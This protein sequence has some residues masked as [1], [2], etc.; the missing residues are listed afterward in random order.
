MIGSNPTKISKPL[1]RPSSGQQKRPP[2]G[3]TPSKME[4]LA[5]EKSTTASID[6]SKPQLLPK[7]EM[8]IE[9]TLTASSK[10]SNHSITSRSDISAFDSSKDDNLFASNGFSSAQKSSVHD[11]QVQ[12]ELRKVSS[13]PFSTK[14][15]AKKSTTAL[16][17]STELNQSSRS[18]NFEASQHL[19]ST[20]NGGMD[21]STEYRSQALFTNRNDSEDH[22]VTKL[23]RDSTRR[24]L[25]DFNLL[26][27][28]DF[29]EEA[30]ME[31]NVEIDINFGDLQKKLDMIEAMQKQRESIAREY[32]QHIKESKTE[33]GENLVDF[34][35]NF[36][37][38]VKATVDEARTME[39]LKEK[40]MVNEG[41][42]QNFIREQITTGLKTQEENKTSETKKKEEEDPYKKEKE[43]I[44]ELDRI[45]AAKEREYRERK[46]AEKMKRLQ[47]LEDLGEEE[48]IS[49]EN[50][51]RIFLTEHNKRKSRLSAVPSSRPDTKNTEKTEDK[52]NA[53]KPKLQANAKGHIK[54]NIENAFNRNRDTSTLT[55]LTPED[56][57]RLEELMSVIDGTLDGAGSEDQLMRDAI[58]NPYDS[59]YG[60]GE[61]MAEIDRRMAAYG[62]SERVAQLGD[63]IDYNKLPKEKSLREQA[64]KRAL[65]DR[66]ENINQRLMDINNKERLNE[67]VDSQTVLALVEQLRRENGPLPY[68][69]QPRRDPDAE[70]IEQALR[71]VDLKL[72]TFNEQELLNDISSLS[73][74][75]AGV[76]KKLKLMRENIE[77]RNEIAEAETKLANQRKN[78]I[79][80]LANRKQT[81]QKLDENTVQGDIDGLSRLERSI[82]QMEQTAFESEER[83]RKGMYETMITEAQ[84]EEPEITLEE[85]DRQ[86]M[87]QLRITNPEL[88]IEAPEVKFEMLDDKDEENGEIDYSGYNPVK[89]ETQENEEES[90]C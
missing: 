30:K 9:R 26:D 2:S 28:E 5:P 50:I 36:A 21:I 86:F 67:V 18:T 31:E 6:Y 24:T 14:S 62:V 38:I 51:D 17:E 81:L 88:F 73:S 80:S 61:R 75:A 60:M 7:K 35:A 54:K 33:D 59:S 85:Y 74:Q 37:E 69:N 52:L 23:G 15:K 55:K 71:E 32:V 40:G 45:L 66:N 20:P 64:E 4:I 70:A 10:K 72:A 34:P 19:L 77:A 78:L 39:E 82:L 42:I 13:K 65:Q 44:K 89:E 63:M 1:T 68:E 3:A 90:V 43:K 11:K 27:H 16:E 49:V 48:E 46:N 22:S 57:K 47:D 8:K 41:E 58:P 53:T 83:F 76:K 12:E 87:D 79:D 84:P 25:E 29:M 56:Q